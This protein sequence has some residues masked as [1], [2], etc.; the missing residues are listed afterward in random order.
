M[1]AIKSFF[2]MLVSTDHQGELPKTPIG[3]LP[4]MI[5]LGSFSKL[6]TQMLCEAP[7]VELLKVPF[8]AT[9]QSLS[10]LFPGKILH[11]CYT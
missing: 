2:R 11:G 9:F 8:K 5:L 4:G 1:G 3:C 6:Y 10:G 7:L